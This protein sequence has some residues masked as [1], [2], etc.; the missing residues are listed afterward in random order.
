[1]K[2]LLSLA[3]VSMG[4]SLNVAG[5]ANADTAGQT[6]AQP[7]KIIYTVQPERI[8][9]APPVNPAPPVKLAPPVNLAKPVELAPPVHLAQPVKLARPVNLAPPVKLAQPVNLAPPVQHPLIIKTVQIWTTNQP[10]W[11]TNHPFTNY[12]PR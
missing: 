2:K 3:I 9:L 11:E 7:P 12:V 8:H 5:Q 6:N 1:M 10:S 4:I